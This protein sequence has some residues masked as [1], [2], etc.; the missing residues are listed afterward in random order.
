MLLRRYDLDLIVTDIHIYI[1]SEV[2][3]CSQLAKGTFAE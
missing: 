2:E 1:H 3:F